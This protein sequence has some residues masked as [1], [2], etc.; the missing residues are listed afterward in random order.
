MNKYRHAKQTATA[1][2]AMI[3]TALALCACFDVKEHLVIHPDGSGSLSI[4]V[5]TDSDLYE[6]TADLGSDRWLSEARLNYPPTSMESMKVLFPGESFVIEKAPDDKT[7]LKARVKFKDISA[8]LNSPYAAVKSMDLSVDQGRLHMRTRTGFDGMAACRMADKLKNHPQFGPMMTEMCANTDDAAYL[9]QVTLPAEAESQKGD[10]AGTKVTWNFSNGQAESADP[11]FTAVIHASCSAKD[12]EFAPRGAARIDLRHFSALVSGKTHL[13]A[14]LPSAADYRG[15][16][17]F[18]PLELLV[19]NSFAYTASPILTNR[20]SLAGVITVPADLAPDQWGPVR[21]LKARDSDGT[22]LLFPVK[23]GPES[24]ESQNPDW[25]DAGKVNS[26]ESDQVHHP[27]TLQF[28]PPAWNSKAISLLSAKLDLVFYSSE[29]IVKIENAV[30][31]NIIR[32]QTRPDSVEAG[33]RKSKRIIAPELEDAGIELFVEDAVDMGMA[34]MVLVKT[35]APHAVI[36]AI[37]FF[38]RQGQP[39]PGIVSDS[40]SEWGDDR[41]GFMAI[42]P[43]RPDPPLSMASKLRY[44]GEPVSVSFDINNLSMM[45]TNTDS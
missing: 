37:G 6:V 44:G 26:A 29:S 20:A 25:F 4:E 30:P 45:K 18:Q 21:L 31:E 35:R 13:R 39:L 33:H 14:D 15:Q 34:L 11:D 3:F 12:I 32:D 8:I 38:D 23:K 2:I 43:G 41:Q 40:Q 22:D 7:T 5:K 9:F 28:R 36:E 19:T 10:A 16:L 1:F 24:A 42:L 27:V 17:R